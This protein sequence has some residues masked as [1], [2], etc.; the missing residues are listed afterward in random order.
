MNQRKKEKKN[1][2]T[3]PLPL[4]HLRHCIFFSDCNEHSMN[5]I[6]THK[7]EDALLASWPCLS[8]IHCLDLKKKRQNI[9]QGVDKLSGK[10]VACF[11]GMEQIESWIRIFFFFQEVMMIEL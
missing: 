4:I 1:D 6:K 10:I 8:S 3:N 11:M 2:K 5:Q 9:H 7:I